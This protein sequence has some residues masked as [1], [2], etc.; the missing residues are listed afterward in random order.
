MV[1]GFSTFSSS[2]GNTVLSPEINN[3]N[4]LNNMINRL[5]GGQTNAHILQGDK[6]VFSTDLSFLD[7][8]RLYMPSLSNNPETDVNIDIKTKI[9]SFLKVDA[10][11][12]LRFLDSAL[13]ASVGNQLDKTFFELESEYEIYRYTV[14]FQDEKLRYTFNQFKAYLPNT[15]YSISKYVGM[16]CLVVD[17]SGQLLLFVIG[18]INNGDIAQEEDTKESIIEPIYGDLFKLEGFPTVLKR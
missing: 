1:R 3:I 7:L 9:K 8:Q 17:E 16:A 12:E 2:S 11:Y 14:G 18:S 13:F 4:T 5:P 15:L 6:I 10:N